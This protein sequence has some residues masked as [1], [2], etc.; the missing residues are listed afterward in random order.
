M[1]KLA[2]P[3][4]ALKVKSL[5]PKDTR[6]ELRDGTVRGLEIHVQPSGAK[7]WYFRSK[8]G[9]RSAIG[10]AEYISLAQA[11]D[12]ANDIL[13]KDRAGDLEPAGKGSTMSLRAFIDK[14]YKSWSRAR[15]KT[16]HAII[17]RLDDCFEHDFY[18]SRLKDIKLADMERWQNERLAAGKA[19][20]TINRDVTAIKSVLS[21]AVKLDM[22]QVHPLKN[23]SLLKVKS[24]AP[25]YL[26][27]KELERLYAAMEKTDGHIVPLTIMALNTGLRRGELFNLQF[28]DVDFKCKQLIVTE[29]KSG[30]IRH[31]PLNPKAIQVM[32]DQRDKHKEGYVFPGEYGRLVDIKRPWRN[33]MAAADIQNFRFHD[34]RHHFASALV[35]NGVDL[36]TVRE[37]LGHASLN[38]TLR[39]AHLAPE[40]KAAAVNTLC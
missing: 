20:A 5:K 1:P 24:R 38:M 32:R 37:L 10:D 16:S 18:D 31:I 22:L 13:R 19:T 4:S 34:C 14:H 26:S 23:L 9:K 28:K 27:A 17:K 11:R 25:R 8:T 39:Y 6:Y 40:H 21:V 2:Q 30:E 15:N 35:M 3:L 33:L 12:T 29:S 7:R 36:N